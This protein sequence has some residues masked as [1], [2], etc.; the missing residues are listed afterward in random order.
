MGSKVAARKETLSRRITVTSSL[1]VC[2]SV[3]LPRPFPSQAS[4]QIFQD[5]VNSFPTSDVCFMTAALWGEFF[6]LLSKINKWTIKE[7]LLP[8]EKIP[9]NP[10]TTIHESQ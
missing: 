9:K 1:Y 3:L 4:G 7:L 6:K 8:P 10:R 5:D 2:L